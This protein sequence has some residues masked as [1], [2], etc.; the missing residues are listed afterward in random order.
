[1]PPVPL[2]ISWRG[3]SGALVR[4]V[5]S[6]E[7]KLMPP[8]LLPI[9]WI[10]LSGGVVLI[11]IS[12]KWKSINAVKGTA[13]TRPRITTTYTSMSINAVQENVATCSKEDYGIDKQLRT[14]RL[15]PEQQCG[16]HSKRVAKVAPAKGRLDVGGLLLP[17]ISL[18]RTP[19][20][21]TSIFNTNASE[22]LKNHITDIIDFLMDVHASV[23]IKSHSIGIQNG[24]NEDTLNGQLKCGF[25]QYIALEIGKGNS[26][27][28][29]AISRY[30]PWLYTTSST[31]QW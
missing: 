24:L 19:L 4:D 28:N 22:S 23:K 10:G 18:R 17:T 20:Y 26:R 5:T 21:V 13:I 11:Q 16:I 27:E 29:R 31:P 25:A 14:Q 8:F 15:S 7:G 30:L 2:P 6:E 3:L 1:M 12:V 9:I